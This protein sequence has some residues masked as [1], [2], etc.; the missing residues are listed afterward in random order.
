MILKQ[1]VLFCEPNFNKNNKPSDALAKYCEFPTLVSHEEVK[2]C[3]PNRLFFN[4]L[5]KVGQNHGTFFEKFMR[6]T[7]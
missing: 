1:F 4:S 2:T 6:K 7:L 3:F 5:I